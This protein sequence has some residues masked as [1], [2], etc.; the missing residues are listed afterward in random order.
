MQWENHLLRHQNEERA[1]RN[2][3]SEKAQGTAGAHTAAG[4]DSMAVLGPRGA[5]KQW[6]QLL[7]RKKPGCMQVVRVTLA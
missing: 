3:S 2:N 6:P 5:L 4:P 7:P 1:E